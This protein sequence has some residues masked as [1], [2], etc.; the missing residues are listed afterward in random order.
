M[1]KVLR[2]QVILRAMGACEWSQCVKPGM[3]IAHLH[4]R[5]AGGNRKA[6]DV[7]DNLMFMCRTHALL[8]DGSYSTGGPHEYLEE[9]LKLFGPRFLLMAENTIAY[10]RAESLR[11]LIQ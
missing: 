10:E 7:L 9:H 6:R 3:E 8:S 2:G 5:G 4:S 11:E 1:D